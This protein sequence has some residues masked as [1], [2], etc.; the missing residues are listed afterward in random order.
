MLILALIVFVTIGSYAG[1]KDCKVKKAVSHKTVQKKTNL[2]Q[3]T[4]VCVNPI[5]LPVSH[6]MAVV[7][8]P[9]RTDWTVTTQVVSLPVCTVYRKNNIVVKECPD[10]M[11]DANGNMEFSSH[12]T[13]LGYYP[14]NNTTGMVCDLNA[15]PDAEN[16][17]NMQDN[18]APAYDHR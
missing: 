13:W 6:R 15:M 18:T 11:Y 1:N 3:E 12:N 16:K 2:Q 9:P 8:T 7:D 10:V 4:K 14:Q 17:V 5:I